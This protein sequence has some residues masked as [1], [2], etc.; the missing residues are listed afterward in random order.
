MKH[1]YKGLS[2][3]SNVGIAE[4]YLQEIGFPIILANELLP[5]R[6]KFYADM[7]N[8]E[9]IEGDIQSSKI[10]NKVIE[11]SKKRKINFIIATP[12]CQ[13]MSRAGKMKEDDPRN[14]LIVIIM[15]IFIDLKPEFM[16]IENVSQMFGTNININ[17]C[18]INICNYIQEIC[19]KYN[20]NV[21]FDIFNAADYGT[22]QNRRRS[23]I[24]IYKKT[25]C[26]KEP[27]K[28]KRIN[29][30]EAIGHLP[31][32]NPGEDS[33]IPFHKAKKHNKNHV[34]WMSHTPTG[35]SAL[36]NTEF[37]PQKNGRKIKAYNTAYKRMRWDKPANTI[38][39]SN[40]GISSQ[41]N[42]H[43]GYKLSNDTYSDPRV[44]TLLELFIVM[45][46]PDNWSPPKWAKDTLI[47]QVIG[48]GVPPKLIKEIFLC[49]EKN[50]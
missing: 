22:P 48:E 40:G 38:T 16:L 32:L 33:K 11:I 4:T 8:S 37:F 5:E 27:L 7:H 10:Y 25:Y 18:S 26:W 21:K 2:L 1:N 46:L 28:Q 44:L 41:T 14:K 24:R 42:V 43:P 17:G 12:P 49:L 29:L 13:G 3:F 9:I 6:C 47:R 20:Y 35:K 39:M 45:G 15:N 19:D 34:L 50:V 36:E 30:F 23:I 31:S